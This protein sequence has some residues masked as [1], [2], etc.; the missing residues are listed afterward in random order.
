MKNAKRLLSAILLSAL[1]ILSLASC[2]D[3]DE[4]KATTDAFLSAIEAGDFDAAAEF[5]HPDIAKEDIQGVF[6]KIEAEYGV[7][8]SDGVKMVR[9]LGFK[10]MAY[11]SKIGGSSYSTVT[12]ITLSGKRGELEVTVVDNDEGYGIYYLSIG[13]EE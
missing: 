2:I 10:S 5:L 1:M 4:A 8:F 3:K 7:N 6:E 13:F 12:E 9:T 11:D